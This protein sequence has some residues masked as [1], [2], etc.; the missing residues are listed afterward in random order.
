[1]NANTDF[2]TSL[3]LGGVLFLSGQSFEDWMA[4]KQMQLS[5]IKQEEI[6]Q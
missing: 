3:Q 5:N 6:I 2:E 1:M 4:D